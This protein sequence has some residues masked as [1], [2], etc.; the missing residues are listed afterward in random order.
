MLWRLKSFGGVV[1]NFFFMTGESGQGKLVSGVMSA[2][3]KSMQQKLHVLLSQKN[4][5]AFL[6]GL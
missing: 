1:L 4:N 6:S 3:S 5:D 2:R